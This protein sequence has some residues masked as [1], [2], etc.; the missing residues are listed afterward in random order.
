MPLSDAIEKLGRAIFES[1]FNATRVAAEAPELAEIR[2]AAIDAIKAKSHRVGGARV[3][4]YNQVRIHLRGIP[5]A[6]KETLQ[7]GF[8]TEYLD[9]ELRE[10]LKR[11]SYRFPED[12]Q[13]EVIAV[14]ELPAP[15]ENWISIETWQRPKTPEAP[16]APAGAARLQ[17][18]QGN[19]NIDEI[20]LDKP[21]VNI[22]RTVD[23]FRAEGPSRRND[24][25]F[26]ED[27]EINRSVSR[28]HAHVV[29]EK[30]TGEYRI[31]NDRWYETGPKAVANCGLWI[32]REGLSQ[33]VHRNTR[34]SVLKPGDE[35][36]LGRA[37]L[38]FVR[39]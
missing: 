20:P 12:M 10:A 19:A 26:S 11:S 27:N 21:R 25:A 23:V 8:L 13:L 35:I 7:G 29:W 15:G 2:L 37:I 5:E 31:V 4:P 9:G 6:Q 24:L 39:D 38:L 34:G 1:P 30:K 16:V 32:I 17:V 14:P 3:F 33:P 36:H 18:K 28:E 22:G